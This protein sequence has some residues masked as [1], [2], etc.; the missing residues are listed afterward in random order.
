[1]VNNMDKL[2]YT[3]AI[4]STNY[5]E[6]KM[7][8]SVDG[9]YEAICK[10][11][12]DCKIIIISNNWVDTHEI[13]K[14]YYRF[15]VK[16]ISGIDY[17]LLIQGVS[18]NR[19]N[20]NIIFKKTSIDRIFVSKHQ[21]YIN[22]HISGIDINILPVKN[23]CNKVDIK[24]GII[25]SFNDVNNEEKNTNKS[26]I[27]SFRNHGEYISSIIMGKYPLQG[28]HN[29]LKLE[30]LHLYSIFYFD[31]NQDQKKT[32]DY[33]IE[34][35]NEAKKNNIKVLNCSFGGWEYLESEYNAIKNARDILFVVSAGNNSTNIDVI[36][37]YPACY[38]LDNII[39]VGAVDINGS[40]Y[41]TS[42]YGQIVDI[43]APGE[44]ICGVVQ[45][46]TTMLKA[47]G[48]S[49]AAPFVTALASLLININ[50]KLTP[51]EIKCLIKNNHTEIISDTLKENIKFINFE[52]SINYISSF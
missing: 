39:V 42:N 7:N 21:W 28:F 32:S 9:I 30:K 33:F 26:N 24:L 22:N 49:S 45:N 29:L 8:F 10:L 50:H 36:P 20:Y 38:N 23:L 25:D 41:K 52:K 18:L 4:D 27:I 12:E 34:A 15:H 6:Y 11:N 31:D 5:I 51:K 46:G 17:R 48:T 1:M 47:S 44:D 40:I 19:C 35:I 2:E 43:F 3:G 37:R 13:Y 16:I 14:D